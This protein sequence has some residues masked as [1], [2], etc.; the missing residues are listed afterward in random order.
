MGWTSFYGQTGECR[1]DWDDSDDWHVQLFCSS[2]PQDVD[3]LTSEPLASLAIFKALLHNSNQVFA[4]WAGRS[5]S[6]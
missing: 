4:N 2:E 3:V 6:M 1:D 5:E